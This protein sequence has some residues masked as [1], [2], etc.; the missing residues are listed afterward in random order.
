MVA[1]VTC[2][3]S[4]KPSGCQLVR[5]RARGK[6]GCKQTRQWKNRRKI[7]NIA[8]KIFLLF[9]FFRYF[10][11]Y[12]GCRALGA[13]YLAALCKVWRGGGRVV[14]AQVRFSDRLLLHLGIGCAGGAKGGGWV[15]LCF[16]H[17]V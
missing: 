14:R 8:D 13:N 4:F 7:F 12:L 6:F 10:A 9:V 15:L 3:R 17:F 5:E 1:V 16:K 11:T 2:K